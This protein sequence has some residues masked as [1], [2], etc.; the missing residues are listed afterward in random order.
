VPQELSTTLKRAF[1]P[2]HG[3]DGKR[4]GLNIK[5]LTC[6]RRV[7]GIPDEVKLLKDTLA[8]AMLL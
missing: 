8:S 5:R 2:C 6:S 4:D 3:A 7:V 1:L